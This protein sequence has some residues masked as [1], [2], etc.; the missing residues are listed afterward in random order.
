MS[1]RVEIIAFGRKRK[2]FRVVAI[3][4]LAIVLA[5]VTVWMSA[6]NAND[7][8]YEGRRL[9]SW[10]RK[11]PHTG[12]QPIDAPSEGVRLISSEEKEFFYRKHF[13]KDVA[14]GHR[15]L[16]AV[17][18]GALPLLLRMMRKRERLQHWRFVIAEYIPIGTGSYRLPREQAITAL[19]DLHSGG[20]D[21]GPIMPEIERLTKDSDGEVRT[22]ARFLVEMLARDEKIRKSADGTAND[23]SRG[24]K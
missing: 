8:V 5:M 22:A 9:S 12:P 21:L 17:G 6:P 13:G 7:P 16:L 20:C 1:S 4:M 18:D 14:E 3:C 23:I 15:A 2:R 19:L 10:L 11:Y 24:L